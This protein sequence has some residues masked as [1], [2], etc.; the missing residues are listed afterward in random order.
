MDKQDIAKEIDGFDILINVAGRSIFTLWT[1]KAKREMYRSRV[2][3]TRKIVDAFEECRKPP[4]RFLSASTI[5]I[6]ENEARVTESS[7]KYADNFLATLVKNWEYEVFRAL[8]VNVKVT[9]MRFGIVLGRESGAYTLM[10]N[11]TRFNLGG[12]FGKGRQSISFIYI[13]DLV[14]AIKFL[15]DKEIEGVV[16]LTT[17]EITDFK[18]LFT[19]LKKKFHALVLWPVPKFVPRLLLGRSQRDFILKVRR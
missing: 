8:N 19:I 17:G 13:H 7:G 18:T 14:R 16:N 5:G 4:A 10:R 11:L 12:Y 15:M 6:Y 9:V 1:K 2:D 3:L